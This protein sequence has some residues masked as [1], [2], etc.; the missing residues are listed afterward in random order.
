MTAP[1]AREVLTIFAGGSEEVPGLSFYGL[2]GDARTRDHP[3]FPQSRWPMAPVPE[4]TSLHG[5]GWRVLSWDLH[6][7]AWPRGQAFREAVLETLQALIDV[8]CRVAWVGAEGIPFCDPPGLF[9]PDCMTGGVLAWLTSDGWFGCPLDPDQ[10]LEP[11]PDRQ[12]LRLRQWAGW[13][14]TNDATAR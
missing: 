8:G 4:P 7:A 14:A 10:P 6:V 11:A 5:E 3:P 9:D 12:L 13:L 1:P 2:T